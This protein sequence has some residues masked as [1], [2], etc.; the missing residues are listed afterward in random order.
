MNEDSDV[1]LITPLLRTLDGLLFG[2]VESDRPIRDPGSLT[3]ALPV[4]PIPQRTLRIGTIAM[5]PHST[6]SAAVMN[7][8]G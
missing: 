3:L 2:D 7:N 8:S 4:D 5:A 6:I 1:P